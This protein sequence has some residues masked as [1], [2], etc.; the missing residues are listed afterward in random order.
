MDRQHLESLSLE[1]LQAEAIRYRLIPGATRPDLI[2]QIMTHLE[3]HGPLLDL[4]GT[5]STSDNSIVNNEAAAPASSEASQ[6]YA[7]FSE[8]MRQQRDEMRQQH[9]EM[10]QQREMF[11]QLLTT[12]RLGQPASPAYGCQSTASFSGAEQVSHPAIPDRITSASLVNTG[13]SGLSRGSILSGIQPAKSITLLASQI[14][15][16]GG[17]E[18]ENV[19][20]WLKKVERVSRIHNVSDDVT[21]LAA[22]S[23]LTKLARNWFDLDTGTINDNWCTFKQAVISRF[24]HETPFY[25][26]VQK[27]EARKWIPSKETFQEYATDKL[28]LMQNLNLSGTDSIS[29]LIAGINSVALKAAAAS[30]DAISVDQF[31][32]KMHNIT[33]LTSDSCN[34][35]FQLPKA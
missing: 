11:Q 3:R 15:C 2:D 31:L 9:E 25:L 29:F 6:L 17:T 35:P 19:E 27:V 26:I 30:L 33:K 13:V 32:K 8:E 1:Q 7:I 20:I 10:R 23:K 5:Q 12:L 4:R 21:L 34:K 24:Q 16:F 22:T 18:D 14:P 28:R